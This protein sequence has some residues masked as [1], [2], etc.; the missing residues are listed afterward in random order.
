MVNKPIKMQVTMEGRLTAILKRM[1][2]DLDMVITTETPFTKK[3]KDTTAINSS[4]PITMVDETQD[5]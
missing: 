4:P 1:T 5:K 3:D 2:M